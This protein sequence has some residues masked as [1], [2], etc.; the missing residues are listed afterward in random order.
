MYSLRLILLSIV[1]LSFVGCTRTTINE[2]LLG[3]TLV[4]KVK[5]RCSPFQ[6]MNGTISNGGFGF[7]ASG[8]AKRLEADLVISSDNGMSVIQIKNKTKLTPT[9]I[10]CLEKV[11]KQVMAEKEAEKK[12]GE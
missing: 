8:S 6:E 3:T 11:S 2:E 5:N 1:V 10:E 12:N 4:D 7:K 9:Y